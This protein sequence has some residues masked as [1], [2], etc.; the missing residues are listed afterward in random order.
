MTKKVSD[1]ELR[2]QLQPYINFVLEFDE[3]TQELWMR[4]F[5]LD[6]KQ[7]HT[8]QESEEL[9]ILVSK[10]KLAKAD[11]SDDPMLKATL[12]AEEI[13]YKE[14]FKK[15]KQAGLSRL[16]V[17]IAAV[18]AESKARGE[19]PSEALE[20]VDHVFLGATSADGSGHLNS[21]NILEA[22]DEVQ[23]AGL[24]PWKGMN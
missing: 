14:A 12:V 11:R 21:R 10:L 6:W 20:L 8:E 24:W 1:T 18:T 17:H 23:K 9:E 3:E 19:T 2:E 7:K 4:L 15:A 22:I 16:G 13:A 5:E